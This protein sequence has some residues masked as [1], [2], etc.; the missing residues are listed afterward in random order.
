VSID[1]ILLFVHPSN[2]SVTLT[3]LMKMCF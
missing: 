3:I 1:H 2:Q